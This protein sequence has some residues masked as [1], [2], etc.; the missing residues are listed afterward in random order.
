MRPMRA[1]RALL[2]SLL[3]LV[4]AG[5]GGDDV[6]LGEESGADVLRAGALVYLEAATDPE[7]DQWN[8]TEELL[9]RF[10]DGDDWIRQLRTSFEEDTDVRWEEVREA[11]GDQTVV[12]VYAPSAGDDPVVVGLTN[13]DDPDRTVEVVRKLNASDDGDDAVTRVVDDWVA[14]SDKQTSIDA[15]LKE[16]GAQALADDAGFTA[17]MEE[18]PEDALSRV[19]F[20]AAEAIEVFGSADPET[21]DMLR[22]L[23]LD[24]LDFGGAWAKAKEEGAELAFT[25]RGDGADRL[26]GTGDPYT[27]ALLERVPEDAFAFYSFRGD[28]AREQFQQFQ[29][30]PLYSMGLREL[31]REL[32]IEVAEL[33]NLFDGEVVF[34][35]RSGAPIPE[36]TLL[37]DSEN[38]GDA[39]QSA[40]RLLRSVAERAGGEVT[41]DGDI[42]TA[43]FEGFTVNLGTVEG[44][45]VLTSAKAAFAELAKEGD[46]LPDSDRYQEAL[47]AAGAPE[48]Y[49]G[50]AWVD[51]AEAVALALG[52]G[53][54]F[55]EQ[56]PEYVRRN[57]EPLRSLVL[58]G[59]EDGNVVSSLAFLEIE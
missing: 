24:R 32:G 17:A 47:D 1:A 46:K 55:G 30:N 37:L 53:E 33:V 18:L 36:L 16:E 19:Y 25:L 15:A 50:L 57:L 14:I 3:V 23:G 2:V 12:A 6:G 13:P 34:Y 31:E 35:A 4:A 5:C 29:D 43:V 41:E 49:T 56:I 52:Y 26:L 40:E 20:D 8:Q 45:V 9:R 42:T 44:A 51:L 21:R 58:Y 22:T 59:E 7:S 11:L 10:P 38:P 54:S 27:S 28:A 39:R 48:Q